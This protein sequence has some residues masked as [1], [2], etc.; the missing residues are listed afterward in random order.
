MA[1]SKTQSS[2]TM[3]DGWTPLSMDIILNYTKAVSWGLAA[4][5]PSPTSRNISQQLAV[6]RAQLDVLQI[7]QEE[8]MVGMDVRKATTYATA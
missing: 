4:I 3:G 5:Q 1:L 2:V 7:L 8:D 6:A